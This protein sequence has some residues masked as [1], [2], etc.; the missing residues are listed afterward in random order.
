MLGGTINRAEP[1]Q[2]LESLQ[3]SASDNIP[4]SKAETLV[5]GASHAEVGAWL[6]EKWNLDRVLVQ[7]IRWHHEPDSADKEH[8]G[9][10]ALCHTANY[11]C[12]VEKIGAAGDSAPLFNQTIWKRLGLAAGDISEMVDRVNEE[13]EKSEILMAF[14]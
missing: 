9:I 7:A 14:V 2:Y 8:W 13:S 3:R 11:I 6:G 4:L 1:T 5:I 12:N 10:A